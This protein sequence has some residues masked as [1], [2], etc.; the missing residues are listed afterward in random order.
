MN[1]FPW[2]L[3]ISPA[4]AKILNLKN[5]YANRL[6]NKK[7][8]RYDTRMINELRTSFVN[9]EEYL[10]MQIIFFQKYKNTEAQAMKKSYFYSPIQ[11]F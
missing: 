4:S 6:P 8:I 9:G 11:K 2:F 10:N 5:I 3:I 7:N 1:V